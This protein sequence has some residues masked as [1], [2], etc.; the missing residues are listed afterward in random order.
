MVLKQKV[1]E[2]R[3]EERE[4]GTITER[5]RKAVPEFGG[6][7]AERLTTQGRKSGA[8]GREDDDV[9]LP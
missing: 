2:M 3:F 4:G 7:G 8:R 6:H 9:T 1:L 5:L